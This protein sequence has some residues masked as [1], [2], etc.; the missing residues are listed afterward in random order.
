MFQLA[1]NDRK[2]GV[3]TGLSGDYDDNEPFFYKR[4]ERT[5]GFAYNT[6]CAV[7]LYGFAAAFRYGYPHKG[8]FF[9]AVVKNVNRNGF[10][11]KTPALPV[12]PREQVIFL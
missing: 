6:L 2:I 1:H 4:M 11:G 8:A 12:C 9:V 10:C 3:D 7:A 5:V